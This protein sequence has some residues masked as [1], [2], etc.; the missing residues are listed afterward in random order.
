LNP[1]AVVAACNSKLDAFR[2]LAAA[3]NV[4]IPRF[5]TSPIE[6][7]GWGT[8]VVERELLRANSGRGIRLTESEDVR[9]NVPLYVEY[10]KKRSEY[11]V[12][13]WNGEVID[14]QQKRVRTGSEGNNFQIRS[15]D[16]GWVFCRDSIVEPSGLRDNAVNAVAALNLNFGAVD[17][18]HNHHAN[19]CYVLEVNTAPGVEGATA[20]R[21]CDA[22]LRETTSEQI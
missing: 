13:V 19:L 22:I 15:H 1:P 7:S 3:G 14:V 10:I 8:K 16:N 12:H 2:L 4:R 18:I 5:T 21:Y 6:A 17:V 11:R 20:I 9:D